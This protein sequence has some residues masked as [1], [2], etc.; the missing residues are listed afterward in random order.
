MYLPFGGFGIVVKD[1]I[2]ENIIPELKMLAF[3]A[4]LRWVWLRNFLQ[5]RILWILRY[6]KCVMF[7]QGDGM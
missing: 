2:V 3:V 1:P 6:S 7:L 5:L 4:E